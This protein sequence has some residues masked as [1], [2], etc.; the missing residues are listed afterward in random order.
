MVLP[1]AFKRWVTSL[2]LVLYATIPSPIYYI[3]LEAF[4]QRDL[5]S[6]LSTRTEHTVMSLHQA[7]PKHFSNNLLSTPSKPYR[8]EVCRQHRQ[9]NIMKATKHNEGDGSSLAGDCGSAA[10]AEKDGQTSK[11]L[12]ERAIYPI[13]VRVCKLELWEAGACPSQ[14][15]EW[16]IS[17]H[18]G[19][20]LPWY[21]TPHRSLSFYLPSDAAACVCAHPQLGAA[22]TSGVE[23]TDQAGDTGGGY[24]QAEDTGEAKA[25]WELPIQ[26]C[27]GDIS[28]E[29]DAVNDMKPIQVAMMKREVPKGSAAAHEALLHRTG[30][31]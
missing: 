13:A 17:T 28:E 18:T 12:L 14:T 6:Q 20:R 1:Y 10:T 16:D 19:H 4:F 9:N 5:W 15:P 25:R 23:V 24:G 11:L 29:E 3:F 7:I 22:R 27:N 31:P 21:S 8:S 26:G 30:V 2:L